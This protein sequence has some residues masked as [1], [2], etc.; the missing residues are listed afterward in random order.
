MFIPPVPLPHCN[1]NHCLHVC[2]LPLL[3][4]FPLSSL[5][6]PFHFPPSPLHPLPSSLLPLLS[7]LS[8]PP[9]P[10]SSLCSPPSPSLL[11]PPLLTLL[12]R[13]KCTDVH[14]SQHHHILQ[15]NNGSKKVNGG[16]KKV[17]GRVRGSPY[18]CSL[19]K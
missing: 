12:H 6:L 9:P 11:P 15:I 16:S 8:S 10:P 3:F 13:L 19:W 18:L 4:L 5:P 7:P 2:S 1:R 14:P 17:N